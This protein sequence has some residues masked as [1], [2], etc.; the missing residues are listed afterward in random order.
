MDQTTYWM[1]GVIAVGLVF[2]CFSV[3]F[4]NQAE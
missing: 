1:L 3:Y 2:Y 4:A